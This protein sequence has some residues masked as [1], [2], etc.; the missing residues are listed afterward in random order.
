MVYPLEEKNGFRNIKG[1]I[2]KRLHGICEAI[3]QT[4]EKAKTMS[5]ITL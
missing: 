5:W 1:P 2:T 4:Y 3:N